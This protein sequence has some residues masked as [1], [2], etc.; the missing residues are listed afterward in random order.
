MS[1]PTPQTAELET[2]GAPLLSLHEVSA[3]TQ[4]GKSTLYSLLAEGKGPR[5]ARLGKSLRFRIADVDNWVDELA[6]ARGGHA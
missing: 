2:L 6:D 1:Q 5:H 3:W 4:I